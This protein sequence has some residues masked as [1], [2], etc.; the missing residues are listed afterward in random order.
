MLHPFVLTN[1]ASIRIMKRNTYIK[2]KHQHHEIQSESKA[3][4]HSYLIGNI[5]RE[6]GCLIFP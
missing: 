4:I 5:S 3:H 1:E 6:R 2:T